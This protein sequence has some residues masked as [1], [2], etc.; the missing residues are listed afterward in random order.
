MNEKRRDLDEEIERAMQ[1][2]DSVSTDDENDG[3]VD[4]ALRTLVRLL[5]QPSP[6]HGFSNRVMTALRD[7]PLPGG[8]RKLRARHPEPISSLVGAAAAV[9]FCAALWAMGVA[10]LF[11]ARTLLAI[12]HGGVLAIR[13]VSFMPQTWRWIGLAVRALTAIIGS[14]EM[15]SVLAVM[16]LLSVLT[17]VALTRVVS[18]SRVGGA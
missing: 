16:T 15:L 18:S 2:L 5:P 11:V 7:A 8:R 14:T 12:V 4:A 9:A 13:L 1:V 3:D 10:Q 6:R 17:F